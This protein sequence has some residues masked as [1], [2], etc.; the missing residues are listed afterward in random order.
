MIIDN[1]DNFN[2]CF[3]TILKRVHWLNIYILF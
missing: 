1:S 3:E 2:D